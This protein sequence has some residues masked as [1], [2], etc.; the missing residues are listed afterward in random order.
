MAKEVDKILD[1]YEEMTESFSQMLQVIAHIT[2]QEQW[3]KEDRACLSACL[4]DKHFPFVLGYQSIPF[5]VR[6]DQK[7]GGQILTSTLIKHR[8]KNIVYT[9][10]E[11]VRLLNLLAKR[12][13]L[14]SSKEKAQVSEQVQK[15]VQK[16]ICQRNVLVMNNAKHSF[17]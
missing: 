11:E 7:V 6:L 8:P 16:M 2:L 14:I 15:L 10:E 3:V 4:D 5:K 9:T 12:E 1:A 13:N 17:R